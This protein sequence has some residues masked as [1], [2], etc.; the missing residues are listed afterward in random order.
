MKKLY[1]VSIS[2]HEYVVAESE[3]EAQD[4][5]SKLSYEIRNN[6]D[7]YDA[8]I[9]ETEYVYFGDCTPYGDHE[10]LNIDEWVKRIKETKIEEKRIAEFDTKQSTLELE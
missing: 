3:K 6:V 2:H 9:Y 1:E 4:I 10:G 8:D 7:V 5:V